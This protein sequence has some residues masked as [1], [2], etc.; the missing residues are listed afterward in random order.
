MAASNMGI[1]MSSAARTPTLGASRKMRTG[2][3][4]KPAPKTGEEVTEGGFE[5]GHVAIGND[6]TGDVIS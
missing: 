3:R 6:T 5:D 4:R 2:P 1:S